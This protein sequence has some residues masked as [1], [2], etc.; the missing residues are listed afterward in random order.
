[1][2]H[3]KSQ[4]FPRLVRA[5][6]GLCLGNLCTLASRAARRPIEP[7]AL[8][9]HIQVQVLPFPARHLSLSL[10]STW[11]TQQ[12]QQLLHTLHHA[13]ALV[14]IAVMKSAFVVSA[15]LG[16][17]LAQDTL[18]SLPTC[19]TACLTKFTTGGNIGSCP[20]LNAACICADANFLNGIACCLVGACNPADQAQA[21]DYASKFCGAQGV[22]VPSSVS[23][24][25]AGAPA[26][27]NASGST[28]PTGAA[29]SSPTSNA[30]ANTV[31]TTK[32]PNAAHPLATPGPELI[33]GLLAALAFL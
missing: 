13:P 5:C 30:S 26:P 29:S 3:C 33:G 19:A 15:L 8:H 25:S 2:E 16:A 22:T 20:S 18:P 6:A 21:V 10:R 27:T 14:S 9:Q 31:T 7:R 1:M 32:A 24:S 28:T 17:V 12:Q 4:P 11:Y 23:C